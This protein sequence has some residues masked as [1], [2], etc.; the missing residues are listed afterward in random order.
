MTDENNNL[1]TQPQENQQPYNQFNGAMPPKEEK[2]N[3]GLA[4]LSY[5]IPIVGL[6]LFLVKKNSKPKT[7]KACGICALVS[8]IINMIIVIV[9]SATSGAMLNSAIDDSSDDTSYSEDNNVV[10]NQNEN[11]S[12]NTNGTIGD[13]KC[14][15]KEA[16]LCK[17]WTGKDAILI[18]Y[19]FTNNGSNPI[20]FDVALNDDV[21]QDGVGLEVAI[22]DEEETDSFVDVDIKPGITKDVKKAYVLRDTTT[23]LEVEI[24]ELLSFS[25]DKLTTKVQ[26]SQ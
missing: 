9:V 20:S 4:I 11:S 8:F 26:I 6:I 24:S 23:D 25:D 16:K 3:I 7:A 14:V 2:A 5:L 21:Y 15:V 10:A 1:Y 19:E 13:Y 18:T 22:L 17:D 12:D